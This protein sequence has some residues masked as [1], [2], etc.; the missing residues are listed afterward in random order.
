M[1]EHEIMQM[2]THTIN[3]GTRILLSLVVFVYHENM[4]SYHQ[5]AYSQ[6][7]SFVFTAVEFYMQLLECLTIESVY[8]IRWSCKPENND[9][10]LA[11][12]LDLVGNICH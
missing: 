12:C 11:E 10:F 7:C 8:H 4:S 2:H 3:S 9:K 6:S 5:L 1:F